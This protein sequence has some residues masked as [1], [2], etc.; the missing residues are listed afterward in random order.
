M[1]N[2]ENLSFKDYLKEI[3]KLTK[4]L[5]VN[6]VDESDGTFN[7]IE[8]TKEEEIKLHYHVIMQLLDYS[9]HN[10]TDSFKA[11]I[12][13]KNDFKLFVQL[14]GSTLMKYCN[15]FYFKKN[16]IYFF[17]ENAFHSKPSLNITKRDFYNLFLQK[18]NDKKFYYHSSLDKKIDEFFNFNSLLEFTTF[19][20]EQVVF[21]FPEI[22]S[23]FPNHENKI[24][25]EFYNDKKLLI[26]NDCNN[27]FSY[28]K[29]A[30]ETNI[31]SD[32]LYKYINP[33]KNNNTYESI[34]ILAIEK[35]FNPQKIIDDSLFIKWF[36]FMAN[37]D[38]SE[39]YKSL[40]RNIY[41]GNDY[42]YLYNLL[43]NKQKGILDNYIYAGK[44]DKFFDYYY[45][46]EPN[47]YSLF[48]DKKNVNV[49]M[50]NF[51]GKDEQLTKL[52]FN[53]KDFNNNYHSYLSTNE[54]DSHFYLL[55]NEPNLKLDDIVKNINTYIL[56]TKLENSLITK[57][58][59][60]KVIKI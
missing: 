12:S 20:K 55:I 13:L 9:S 8:I 11:V 60:E 25:D 3:L 24:H 58:T 51:W 17:F 1:D 45:L 23:L 37:N 53:I 10:I 22:F 26:S 21:T 47:N 35:S 52:I 41:Y 2:D 27:F 5:L 30:E 50:F 6:F 31:T 7:R 18:E 56:N 4:T 54:Q 44:N 43:D 28:L 46:S 32:T 15:N 49:N 42:L 19:N 48:L 14:E 39:I 34:A 40:V 33:P 57:Q 36:K 29:I 38:M 59:K 16:D